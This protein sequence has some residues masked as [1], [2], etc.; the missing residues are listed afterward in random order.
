MIFTRGFFFYAAY[1]IRL[2]IFLV[3][4]R[5][6]LLVAN[7][8]DT[9]PANLLVS[10]I[11]KASLIFDSHEYFTGSAELVDRKW[12][13]G[14]WKWIER[15]CL[16]RL[17]NCYTVNQSIAE[18][19]REEYG[20][21]FK[22]VRNLARK[23]T[24]MNVSRTEL[25]LPENKSI[26]ILQGSG[27]NINRGA[28]EAI[29]SMAYLDDVLLLIIGGGDVYRYLKQ[30]AVDLKLEERV[31]FVDRQPYSVLMKYT[32][33]ANLGLSLDKPV[34]LNYTFS[35]PNKLFD[36]I[37]ARI[38]VL[39]SNLVEVSKVIHEYKIG[40]TIENHDP[41]HIADKIMGMLSDPV[42][43]KKW[44]TNLERAADE[45]SWEGEEPVLFEIYRQAGLE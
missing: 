29:E 33:A 27:I 10:R 38:P 43:I 42:R 45:L 20:L 12:V 41:A 16:P 31:R 8:L 36:Y 9:L 35:L 13:R 28:E 39:G 17:N 32:A 24:V 30:L 26:L 23:Y 14:I 11:R 4:K 21:E 22:V 37:Q 1:N 25:D 3:F 6:G 19:Y 7:D 5:K 34:G 2:F 15:F 44:K 18:L 40:D